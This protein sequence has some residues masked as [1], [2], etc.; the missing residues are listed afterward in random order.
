MTSTQPALSS[1]QRRVS[2]LR[3]GS[4]RRFASPDADPPADVNGLA[5]VLRAAPSRQHYVRNA[6][7]DNKRLGVGS[8]PPP[9]SDNREQNGARQ[10]SYRLDG[11]W[12]RGA[13]R[14]SCCRPPRRPVPDRPRKLY[15][16]RCRAFCGR[17]RSCSG[18]LTAPGVRPDSACLARLGRRTSAAPLSLV[19]PP[20][21]ASAPCACSLELSAQSLLAPSLFMFPDQPRS[22]H[23]NSVLYINSSYETHNRCPALH[24]SRSDLHRLVMKNCTRYPLR[25]T[26][27]G[28]LAIRRACAC[29]SPA[30]SRP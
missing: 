21:K 4:A 11:G 28:A 18:R 24:T 2:G 25:F 15:D 20:K 26:N 27:S 10:Q 23:V 19:V 8:A 14:G 29:T 16:K 30:F 13:Q 5:A 1:R 12:A 3:L 9:S 22:A 7:P 17:T 6:P